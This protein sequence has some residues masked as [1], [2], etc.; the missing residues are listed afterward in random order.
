MSTAVVE[1][2]ALAVRENSA[3]LERFLPVMSMDVAMD[4]RKTV[5]QAFKDLMIEGEDYG[6]VAGMQRPSL[7]QPGAQKLDNLFGL[8]PRY[9]IE[10]IEED[11]TGEKHGAEPFFRYMIRCQCMRGDFVM[12]E[13]I[14][15]CNSWESKYRYRNSE[16][17]CPT[18]GKGSIIQTKHKSGAN[19][20]KPKNFWCAPFKGGCGAGF[21]IN[22]AAITG[23]EAGRKPNPEIFDSVNTLLKMAEKRAHLLATINATSASEF[24]TQDIE[25]E[26]ETPEAVTERRLSEEKAKVIPE[27]LVLMRKRWNEKET[28]GMAFTY[29]RDELIKTAAREGD[30]AFISITGKLRQKFPKGGLVKLQPADAWA[31]VMELFNAL[32]EFRKRDK[33]EMAGEIDM[34]SLPFDTLPSEKKADPVAA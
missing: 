29:L 4:R 2:T 5:V 3:E 8:V 11:W 14:G 33:P 17:S 32:E 22:D 26:Q 7:F 9:A 13:G 1:T 10:R 28:P 25:P 16:R 18:C 15:E 21:A 31:T 20:G 34:D 19:Q 12:G 23:Q 27:E 30:E 24:F 6:K